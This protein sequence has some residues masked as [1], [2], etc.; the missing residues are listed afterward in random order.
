M[1][2]MSRLNVDTVTD[3]EWLPA[4]TVTISSMESSDTESDG[5][6]TLMASE[7][8]DD[9]HSILSVSSGSVT[10]MYS[11]D[12]SE[13]EP[14]VSSDDTL[15]GS[16][17]IN[18]EIESDFDTDTGTD[19]VEGAQDLENTL[20][21]PESDLDELPGNALDIIQNFQHYQTLPEVIHNFIIFP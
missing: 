18:S 5:D 3:I 11:I 20:S 16:D 1:V 14:F 13:V 17:G 12:F 2:Q 7:L 4:L 21:E 10:S 19:T 15:V 6:E 9:Q 8:D